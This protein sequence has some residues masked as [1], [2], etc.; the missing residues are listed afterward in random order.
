MGK[1]DLLE[2]MALRFL[3]VISSLA[4]VYPNSWSDAGPEGSSLQLEQAAPAAPFHAGDQ[5]QL[6]VR[7]SGE[8]EIEMITVV[9]TAHWPWV[10][11]RFDKTA[12]PYELWI[13]FAQ[14]R[15]ARRVAAISAPGAK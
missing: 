7:S 15:N 4:L 11:V 9:Q 5:L 12:K 3:P 10:L 1:I 8:S 6:D 2:G 13:N 14:V